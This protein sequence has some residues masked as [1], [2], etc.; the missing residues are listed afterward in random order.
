MNVDATWRYR[1][2]RFWR[3]EGAHSD[4]WHPESAHLLLALAELAR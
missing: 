1:R 4:I 2:G 3:P